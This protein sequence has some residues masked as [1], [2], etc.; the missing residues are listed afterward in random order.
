MHAAHSTSGDL[1]P[2][3]TL[4]TALRVCAPYRVLSELAA[5]WPSTAPEAL[6][7]PTLRLS[8]LLGYLGCCGRRSRRNLVQVGVDA[9]TVQLAAGAEGAARGAD[10]FY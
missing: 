8:G 5:W 3:S 6:L 9:A 1:N 7:K 10:V 2:D 4:R